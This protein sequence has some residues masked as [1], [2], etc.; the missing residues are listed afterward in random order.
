MNANANANAS[1]S[2]NPSV[3]LFDW[4]I[5][6]NCLRGSKAND[7]GCWMS[8]SEKPTFF[9]EKTRIVE[10]ADGQRF[11]IS[12]KTVCKALGLDKQ[13]EKILNELPSTRSAISN[14]QSAISNQQ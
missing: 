5:N 13:S 1:A 12:K 11:L 3:E 6:A 10:L 9:C 7:N 8:C 14:Q 2:A 4:M